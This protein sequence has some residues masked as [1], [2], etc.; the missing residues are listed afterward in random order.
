MGNQNRENMKL[1]SSLLISLVTG[2]PYSSISNNYAPVN[3][4]NQLF[5]N[6]QTDV[7]NNVSLNFVA[8]SES[9]KRH[10]KKDPETQNID[11][12]LAELCEMASKFDIEK[13]SFETLTAHPEVKKF[14]EQNA[15]PGNPVGG[16]I[17]LGRKCPTVP[18]IADFSVEKDFSPRL[19][20]VGDV[21][22]WGP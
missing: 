15:G 12:A 6:M 1:F 22:V 7:D 16:V 13:C 11:P 3:N 4:N 2:A 17:T 8:Q 5:F 19:C 18:V 10:E 20:E 14:L 21:P 9:D